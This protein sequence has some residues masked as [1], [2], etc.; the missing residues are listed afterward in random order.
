MNPTAI[1]P[2]ILDL[3]AALMG[4]VTG[5]F[6]NVVIHRV[7]RGVSIVRPRSRCPY[8]DGPIRAGD[9]IPVLSWVLLR[10]RCRRCSAPISGRY[11]FLEAL[12][13]AL[14]VLCVERFGFTLEAL[15]AAVLCSLL[16][17]LAAIDLEHFLLPDRI[18]LPGI[19]I[20][21]LLQRWL[22]AASLL[23]AVVGAL[24][25]AGV[26]I[27]LINVWYWLHDEESMGLGD[28]NM[29]AMIGAFLGW[30]GVIST[31]FVASLLG[32]VVGLGL[33]AARRLTLK[34]KLPFGFFLALGALVS[35]FAGEALMRWYAQLL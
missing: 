13:G 31:L 8:C 4:L 16:I 18:T 14:F 7:P 17:V 28:V 20:G 3:Y 34:G 30:Q 12:T 32:A 11:P 26:L 33:I 15:A 5:S 22:P 25:G 35:L 27:L 21:W 29:L 6:L 24:V 19:V 2:W 10:G 23:E 1:A 9:N